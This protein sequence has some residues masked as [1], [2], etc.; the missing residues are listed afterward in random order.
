MILEKIKDNLNIFFFICYSAQT[1]KY[2]FFQDAFNK[3]SLKSFQDSFIDFL[4]LAFLSILGSILTKGFIAGLL[5]LFSIGFVML[6]CTYELSRYFLVPAVLTAKKAMEE[7]FPDKSVF[8]TACDCSSSDNLLRKLISTMYLT[9]KECEAILQNKGRLYEK[10]NRNNFREAF[11]ELCRKNNRLDI[12]DAL[13]SEPLSEEASAN[14]STPPLISVRPILSLVNPNEL[15]CFE[16]GCSLLTSS[17]EPM[18]RYES[19]DSNSKSNSSS[20]SVRSV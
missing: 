16:G 7:I 14:S 19:D 20:N 12:F 4:F 10:L 8:V 11:Y 17:K 2:K 1:D 5:T 15:D 13:F 18:D 6:P 3:T 9:N